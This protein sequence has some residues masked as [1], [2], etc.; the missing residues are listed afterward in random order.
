M[1]LLGLLLV[2][3][4]LAPSA[5]VGREKPVLARAACKVPAPPDSTTI[6]KWVWRQV[7]VGEIAD[8]NKYYNNE[9]LEPASSD[10]WSEARKLRAAF[11]K[12]ILVVD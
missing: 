7:C 8:L 6:E 12:D 4:P 3:L 5:A 9:I 1:R 2:V 11:L 10:G